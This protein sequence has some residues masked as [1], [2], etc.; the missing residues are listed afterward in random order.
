M[1][2]LFLNIPCTLNTIIMLS[3]R[4]GRSWQTVQTQIGLLGAVWSGSTLFATLSGSFGCITQYGKATL[5]KFFKDDY[6]KIFGY[7]NF[8]VVQCA[9]IRMTTCVCGSWWLYRSMWI[10]FHGQVILF[11]FFFKMFS[12]SFIGKAWGELHYALVLSQFWLV[13]MADIWSS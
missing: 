12:F 10:V 11:C 9:T 8:M 2:T 3:F 4:T 5:F 7:P 13:L 1:S 6:S